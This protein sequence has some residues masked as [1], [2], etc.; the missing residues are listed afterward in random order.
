MA[1]WLA[2]LEL[3]SH[4]LL[5]MESNAARQAPLFARQ[6]ERLHRACEAQTRL[7]GVHP[8]S[9]ASPPAAAAAAGAAAAAAS[10]GA[11]GTAA[12]AELALESA[13]VKLLDDEG[14]ISATEHMGALHALMQQQTQ[15]D[16]RKV[17]LLVLLNT[18][19]M[20]CLARFVKSGGLS[21]LNAWLNAAREAQSTCSIV[22]ILKIL[23]KLPVTMS[24][25]KSCG[26]GKS[27]NKLRK[28]ESDDVQSAAVSVVNG[29]KSL[30]AGSGAGPPPPASAAA[31]SAAATS[32]G[33]KRS[34][35]A[36][37][38]RPAE[39]SLAPAPSSA[40]DKKRAG[41][42]PAKSPRS[43]AMM[44]LDRSSA[45]STKRTTVRL[46]DVKQRAAARAKAKPKASANSQRSASPRLPSPVPPSIPA[47]S[48]AAAAVPVRVNQ[49]PQRAAVQPARGT[50]RGLDARR[51]VA[52][53]S[54]AASAAP[55]RGE[56]AKSAKVSSVGSEPEPAETKKLPAPKRR[57]KLTWKPDESLCDVCFFIPEPGTLMKKC[58]VS[59]QEDQAKE[60]QVF[61]DL[62]LQKKRK[63]EEEFLVRLQGMK[64][65]AQWSSPLPLEGAK[66]PAAGEESAE[67]NQQAEREKSVSIATYL[68]R[69]RIPANPSEPRAPSDN[70][71]APVPDDASIPCIPL[72]EASAAAPA[73]PDAAHLLS[74]IDPTLLQAMAQP[75]HQQQQYQQPQYQQQYQQPQYQQQYQQQQ[76]YR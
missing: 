49:P 51:E 4:L 41:E 57:R 11:A 65:S 2:A 74:Q 26:I 61:Q 5:A 19:H 17:L 28:H 48:A 72:N 50:K 3:G 59:K 22:A 21:T 55:R 39:L 25:L 35:R 23:P 46:Q 6:L 43:A 34:R 58:N 71:S 52:A 7:T 60:K 12:A 27:V 31:S 30:V 66:G 64:A 24:A 54:A 42:R 1:P 14:R 15:E 36:A 44:D 45:E 20:P 38:D 29:W 10:G 8:I 53:A 18:K 9:S 40:P 67:R 62:A 75:V 68:K 32:S 33:R 13:L 63:T 37:A 16:D 70:G 56:S 73:Q 76:Q 69:D 47:S